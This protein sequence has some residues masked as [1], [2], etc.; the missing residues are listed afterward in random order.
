MQL[1]TKLEESKKKLITNPSLKNEI[2][3]QLAYAIKQDELKIF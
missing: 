3:S 2:K 1:I